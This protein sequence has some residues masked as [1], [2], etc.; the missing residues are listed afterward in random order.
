MTKIIYNSWIWNYGLTFS[1]AVAGV[2]NSA[3]V[4]LSNPFSENIVLAQ[5]A[6]DRTLGTESSVIN[7]NLKIKGFPSDQIEGGATRGTNLFH[8]FEEFSVREGQGAYFVNPEGIERILSRVTGNSVSQIKGKLGVLGNADLF[9]INPNGIVFGPNATLDLKGSFLAT[10]GN[11]L[12][13][14]DGTKFSATETSVPSL[15]TISIPAGLQFRETTGSILNQSQGLGLQVQPGKTLALIGGDI[16]IQG[17]N[18][19]AP[20]AN[21]ELG[22]VAGT[23]QVHLQKIDSGWALSYKDVQNFQD[24]ELIQSS[25]P[26]IKRTRLNTISPD[27][28]GGGSIHVQ[29]R[30]V[31]VSNGSQ[32]AG[33]GADIIVSASE[34]VQVSGT[35]LSGIPFPSAI[36]SESPIT[37]KEGSVAINAK[38][39]IVL[40]GG[41]ITSATSGVVTGDQ[42]DQLT[43]TKVAGG[44][45]IINA[46]ESVELKGGKTKTGLFSS[47]ESFGA[48]GN[49][50]IITPQLIVRDGADISAASLGID[51]F[52]KP[53]A[54]G[55]A[56]NINI[57]AS[58]SLKLNG[59][60]IS[61]ETNGLGGPAG[62][63]TIET[64]Q[65][66]ISDGSKVSV[67]GKGGQAGNLRI[68]ANSLTL[69]RGDITAEVGK[70]RA[71]G[72]AN[73]TLQI[74]DLLSLVNES[75]ISATANGDANG[76][77]IL[78]DPTFV[79]LFP[80]GPNGS[81][82]IAKADRG[83][84]GSIK[85]EAQGIFG[86]AERKA[87]DGNRSNDIDASSEFGASGQVQLTSTVDPNQGVTQIPETVVDPNALVAQSPC[88]RG[89]QSQ[90][91]R[92][93]R[94]GLPPN[95]S[96]DF[97]GGATQVGLVKPAPS[98][99]AEAQKTS[100]DPG[101]SENHNSKIENP[102]VPAQ[103]WSFKDNGE[104]VLTAYNPVVTGEQRLQE[105][106]FGCPAF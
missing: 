4:V 49:I 27:G 46:S 99:V 50:D 86:T 79:L 103:G 1:L 24:I 102:I 13:F 65:L 98:I 40:N 21:I 85:I 15:L 53:I 22:S 33:A 56:G 16:N 51:L 39:L 52:G 88:K 11:S 105:N 41:R 78:I 29:G 23:G 66:N 82:I 38:N 74:R 19:V 75:V 12:S 60:I 87:S 91:T 59:G 9:L 94:G 43:T 14:E 90:F 26:I 6:P 42:F 25:T 93:G 20:R 69:N 2:I 35:A 34:I 44:N 57:K 80:S 73:I 72:G 97:S 81:D 100:S 37:G 71:E 10:T 54:T 45:L 89:S 106:P 17:G 48:A 30:R 95:L 3:T 84:G 96:D 32:I 58:E 28:I 76:G 55:A 68:A 8:S 67:S 31:I 101:P 36:G 62:N 77:N 64:G 83:K 61:T 92:T 5:I 18:I 63:L 7:P 104:V 47:T 70:S